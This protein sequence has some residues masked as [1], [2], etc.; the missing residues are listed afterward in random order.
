MKKLL[1]G[2]VA[3]AAMT[4][5][6]AMAADMPVKAPPPGRAYDWSGFYIGVSAGW[7]H[8]SYD[9]RYANPV[10]AT[11]CAPFSASVDNAIF[12][13]HVGVQW[14]FGWLVIGG[15]VAGNVFGRWGHV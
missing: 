3:L 13:L 6:P 7:A 10:P 9:W 5:G 1:L 8:S 11:C 4:A 2:I 14:Q 12:D 15:E